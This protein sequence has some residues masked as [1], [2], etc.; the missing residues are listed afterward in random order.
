MLE[1]RSL[2][3]FQIAHRNANPYDPAEV[4][5]SS[6]SQPQIVPSDDEMLRDN[7][8]RHNHLIKMK[9][10]VLSFGLFLLLHF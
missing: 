5:S 6:L 10:A 9:R 8:G 2:R 7:L 4:E 3:Q 1:T